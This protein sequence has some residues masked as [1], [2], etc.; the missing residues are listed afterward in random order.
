MPTDAFTPTEPNLASAG[1]IEQQRI[2]AALLRS[3]FGKDDWTRIG[4]FE[5]LERLG[6]GGM[7]VVFAARDPELSREVAIKVLSS[8]LSTPSHQARLRVEAQAMAKLNHPNV[9]TVY[10]V[11]E[12]EGRLF[13]AME[14]IDGP[15]LRQWGTEGPRPWREVLEVYLQAGDGLVAAHAA[16]LV[17]RDFKPDN[18][19]I[20][21]D[22]RVRVLDFG[23]AASTGTRTEAAVDGGARDK[24]TRTGAVL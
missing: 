12:H 10:E 15:S 1:S 13:V 17:H 24:L 22:A 2:R 3:L 11:G 6:K 9:A 23:L 20:G 21:P 4:R 7:G 18:A 16:G 8:D 19:M 14:L 5:V